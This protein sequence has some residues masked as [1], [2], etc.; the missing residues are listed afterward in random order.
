MYDDIVVPTDGS[1]ASQVAVKHA[2]EIAKDHN[3]TVHAVYV[4]DTRNVVGDMDWS[5]IR[6]ELMRE[7][8]EATQR[9][10]EKA[11]ELDDRDRKKTVVT[12][13]EIRSGVPS[14]EILNYSR[15]VNADLIVM[16]TH[17]RTGLEKTV[18]GSV[19]EKI[20]RR[21]DVPVLAAPYQ[22]E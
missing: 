9:V 20:V 8:E 12:M 15:E 21:A 10:S 14:E 11:E 16:S 22:G 4:I 1:E 7:G 17:G 19:T 18:L 13:E 2:V 5:P 3:A 6:D